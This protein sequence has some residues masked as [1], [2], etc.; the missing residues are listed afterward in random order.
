MSSVLRI[1]AEHPVKPWQYQCM[2]APRPDL[3]AEAGGGWPGPVGVARRARAAAGGRPEA[4][5]GGP[6]RPRP[7]PRPAPP[8]GR[9]PHGR[10][11]QE[12]VRRARRPLPAGHVGVWRG[13]GPPP[14]HTGIVPFMDLIGQVM[15]RPEYKEAPRVFVIVDNGSDHRGQAAARRLRPATL[16]RTRS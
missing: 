9:A 8:A 5:G 12:G 1:L 10:V 16:T 6:P 3:G 7:R 14:H 11:E 15:N 13:S 2:S 4:V